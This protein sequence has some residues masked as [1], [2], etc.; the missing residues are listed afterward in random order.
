LCFPAGAAGHSL[1][2]TLYNHRY[3]E[4]FRGVNAEARLLAG[5]A[6]PLADDAHAA[7]PLNRDAEPDE[8][9]APTVAPAAAD[10]HVFNRR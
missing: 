4:F 5:D 8:A 7:N 9:H 10:L 2:E 3:T 6:P 1:G